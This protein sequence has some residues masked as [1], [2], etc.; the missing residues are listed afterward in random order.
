MDIMKFKDL[1]ILC[2]G[3]TMLFYGVKLVVQKVNVQQ[4]KSEVQYEQNKK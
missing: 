2:V 3:F 4:D 1:L